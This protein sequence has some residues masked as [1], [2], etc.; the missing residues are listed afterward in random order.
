[1]EFVFV[2][3]RNA[4]FPEFYPHGFLPFGPDAGS[5]N[6][7]PDARTF[8]L[9][10]FEAAVAR[11]GFFV[12]RAYAERQPHLKQ[13]IP[14]SVIEC[15]GRVLLFRR[16]STGGEVRLHDKHSIGIGGHIN[17]EDLAS[18]TN[19]RSHRNPIDAGTRR[20]V[21]EELAVR[22]TYDMKRLGILNDDSNPVGAVHVGVV[23]LITVHGSVD[24]RERDQLEGRLV[25]T[26]ELG[27]MLAQGMNFETWSGLL[28]PRL[29]EILPKPIAA[30]S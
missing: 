6:A 16:L 2:V 19:A 27:R 12:E 4:L 9:A 24:I 3:P 18:A 15:G 17:P 20:E 7:K 28:I 5:A 26:D 14:Y 21:D 8:D 29:D 10:S 25:E 13:V 30:V 1:M 11:D 23:Q 22:G